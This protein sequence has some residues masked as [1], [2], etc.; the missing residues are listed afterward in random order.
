MSTEENK[1]LVGR[2]YEESFRHN[3]EV[4]DLYADPAIINGQ[5][6]SRAVWRQAAAVFLA[7]F[8]DLDGTIEDMVAE[9]DRVVVRATGG[10]T[11]R[12]DFIH[13]AV[14]RVP[15]TG[16]RVRWSIIDSFRIA[17]GKVVEE[18]AIRD[19][20]GMLQQMG[21][22]PAP[23]PA[24]GGA[25]VTA[26]GHLQSAGPAMPTDPDEAKALVRRWYEAGGNEGTLDRLDEL[27]A[28]TWAGHFPQ[29]SELTGAA[30]HKHLLQLFQ[31]AFPDMR[32]TVED[33]VAEG[34]RVASRYTA[35][36]THRGELRGIPPTGKEVTTIGMNIHRVA[37]GKIAEQWAQYDMLGL[38]QQL[39]GIPAPGQ[40]TA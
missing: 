19:T 24:G 8:P 5:P 20:L 17:D 10:A 26:G 38:L 37:G 11:H 12:G 28:P 15:P 25:P 18:W 1:A 6:L 33:L 34:D 23:P 31:A 40:T 14:G 13:P 27:Y 3:P 30:S 39:G 9:G 4:V 35:C 21:A 7:A 32:Y 36:G 2:I 29:D 22:I 16:R